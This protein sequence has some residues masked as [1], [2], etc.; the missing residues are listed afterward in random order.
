[1]ITISHTIIATDSKGYAKQ[2]ITLT[3]KEY[4]ELSEQLS[5]EI[6]IQEKQNDYQ[7]LKNILFGGE[8]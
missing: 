8:L 3:H 1:M 6:V 2:H 4:L 5:N 7:I